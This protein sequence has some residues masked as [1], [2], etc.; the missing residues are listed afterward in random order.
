MV[1][2]NME[3]FY[4]SIQGWS[5]GIP[6]LYRLVAKNAIDGDHFVEIGSWRGKSSAFMAVELVNSGKQVRF[7][8]VDTWKGS[9]EHQEGGI[10][11]DS[12]VL[13]DTLF[14]EFITNMKPVDGYYN[15]IRM[16]SVEAASLYEDNSLNF[17]FI[18]GAHDYDSV[19]ADIAAWFPK[20]KSGGVI[21]GHDFPYEPVQRAVTKC[22]GN[23]FDCIN[24]CWVTTKQ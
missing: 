16:T 19:M 18:D 4:E 22:F 9:P 8:C 1:E 14:N 3:H 10:N 6:D 23:Q 12:A 17:V 2:I 13:D 11:F 21:S 5:E 24:D 20:V 7:D 15:P